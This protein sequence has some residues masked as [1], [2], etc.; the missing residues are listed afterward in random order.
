MNVS[1]EID[2]PGSMRESSLS[3]DAM[4]RLLL[5]MPRNLDLPVTADSEVNDRSE[6]RK[7]DDDQ[8]PHRFRS[9]G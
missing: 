5:M 9:P 8:E 6:D 2:E 3:D 4:G 7:Q 1:C